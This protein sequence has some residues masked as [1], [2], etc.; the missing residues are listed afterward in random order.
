M[1]RT[2][3]HARAHA[4]APVR[5]V[6]TST[7]AHTHPPPQHAR[8]TVF[9]HRFDRFV[10]TPT[11]ISSADTLRLSLLLA[12]GGEFAFVVLASAEKLGAIPYDLGAVLT[13]IVLISMCLTPLLGD[14][15]EAATKI[16]GQQELPNKKKGKEKPN[17]EN[18]EQ[19]EHAVHASL[20]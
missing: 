16:V 14:I 7:Q 17:K 15:A 1:V 12:G 6:Y 19:T 18:D 5:F 20:K 3:A 8:F 9:R 4:Y 2:H 10:P 11:H 13:A